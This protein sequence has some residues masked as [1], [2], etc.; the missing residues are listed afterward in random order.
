[1]LTLGTEEDAA[2]VSFIYN[3]EHGLLLNGNF[4]SL[5][6]KN[7]TRLYLIFENRT[8]YLSLGS[9]RFSDI[10]LSQDLSSHIHTH[11]DSG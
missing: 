7:D 2:A 6:L 3:S 4:S 8:L 9:P 11:S 1:M 10:I 5:N